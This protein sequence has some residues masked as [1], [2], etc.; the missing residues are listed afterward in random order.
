MPPE[1][2][3]W[4][5]SRGRLDIFLGAIC[6]NFACSDVPPPVPVAKPVLEFRVT[7][8]PSYSAASVAPSGA[9]EPAPLA[10][11]RVASIY[12][13]DLGPAQPCSGSPD[14]D[15]REISNP[16]RPNQ[17]LIETQI[18][19]A[20][21]C[22]TEVRVGGVAAGLL[23]VSA[24]QINFK[25]PQ[26]A[27]TQGQTSIRVLHKGQAGPSVLVPLTSDAP[28][29]SP[30]R[31]AGKMWSDLHHVKW[32]RQY[33]PGVGRCDSVPAH[34][35]FRNALNGHAYYCAQAKDDVIAESFYYPV[36]HTNP[37]LLLLRADIRP[38]NAYPELS[39]EVEQWLVRRLVKAYGAGVVPNH[40]Y[41]I[42][43]ARPNP[44]LSWRSGKL[45]IFLHRNRNHVA[46]AGVREGVVL[47]AVRDEILERR[48]A[49]HRLDETYRSLATLSPPVVAK[50]LERQ[51]PGAYF[52]AAPDP[53]SEPDRVKS[54]R[55]TRVALLRLLRQTTGEPEQRAAAL[56]AADDLARRLAGL[57]VVRAINNGSE[58]L[59]VPEGLEKVRMQLASY[60]VRFGQIGHY[61]GALD[62]DSTLL[63][64]AWKEYPGTTW[65]QRAFLM[66]QRVGCAP[67]GFGCKNSN[68]FLS[69]IKQGESFLERY[70][71]TP[72]RNEQ[73]HHLALANETW[74]SLSQ[75]EP[76]DISAQGAAVTKASAERARQKAIELYE[77]LLRVA[78][79]TPEAQ[80]AILALPRLQLKLGIGE[81]RFFCFS[82]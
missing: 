44:G 25:V 16:L 20:K 39:A 51:L 68:C 76:G 37:Q 36:D 48:Q 69:V 53:K 11:G 26:A 5:M 74:W 4:H 80:A 14:P 7:R 29:G 6:L 15:R 28:A 9:R 43:A 54:E 21:L 82:C 3:K 46:P 64:R 67:P 77:Y 1:A 35:G 81:R 72:F 18:F 27:K 40:I 32:Q 58:S 73:I 79:E 19:P 45:T 31:I 23:Y 49:I 42:G 8:T 56:V 24:G 2:S 10:P 66:L 55:Q 60:G 38:V 30:E 50:E 78:P 62:Y 57:L 59:S 70:P 71:E 34:Q 22:E 13:R 12:G 17:T 47:I 63:Q 41:E 33:A 65:G 61:S 52:A 75:A